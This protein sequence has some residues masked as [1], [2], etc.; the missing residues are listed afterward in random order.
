MG[1]GNR[2]GQQGKQ[3]HQHR[4]RHQHQHRH[5]STR[6]HIPSRRQCMTLAQA[7]LAQVCRRAQ[8]GTKPPVL[9]ARRLSW[10]QLW[11]RPARHGRAKHK[12]LGTSGKISPR[13]SSKGCRHPP[14]LAYRPRVC[15]H[16]RSLPPASH[17][18][19]TFP[20]PLCGQRKPLPRRKLGIRQGHRYPHARRALVTPLSLLA[21]A[22]RYHPSSSRYQD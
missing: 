20:I 10:P 14:G 18:G 19:V 17:P 15:E 8:D 4:H 6:A 7:V 3:G 9:G 21:P 2:E 13:S 1:C 12:L 16:G 11:P 22:R 5:Q